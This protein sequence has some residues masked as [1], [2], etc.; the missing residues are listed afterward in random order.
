MISTAGANANYQRPRC[1]R[2]LFFVLLYRWFPSILKT[3]TVIKP[4]QRLRIRI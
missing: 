2:R 1:R 4:A 3:M